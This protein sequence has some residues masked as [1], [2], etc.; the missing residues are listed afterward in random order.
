[1]GAVALTTQHPPVRKSWYCLRQKAAAVPSV[2]FACGLK[3]TEYNFVAVCRAGT[4]DAV[5]SESFSSTNG[6]VTTPDV[7]TVAWAISENGYQ[8]EPIG[9][10]CNK[11]ERFNITQTYRDP[12]VGLLLLKH[13]M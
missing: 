13:Q 6:H 1:V 3:A 9:A 4:L 11:V 10:C 12:G 7:S 2:V 8:T 5:K